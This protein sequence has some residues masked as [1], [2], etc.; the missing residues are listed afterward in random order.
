VNCTGSDHS[1]ASYGSAPVSLPGS[2][3]WRSGIQFSPP[4]LIRD[5]KRGVVPFEEIW[6][7]GLGAEPQVGEGQQVGEE[8]GGAMVVRSPV[9][10]AGEPEKQRPD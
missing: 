4:A 1:V 10:A 5:L 7:A 6:L 2:A 3:L 8:V 9:A